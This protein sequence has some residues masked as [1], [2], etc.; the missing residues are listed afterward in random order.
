M[1]CEGKGK[2]GPGAEVVTE[3]ER[4]AAAKAFS[5]RPSDRNW[6]WLYL[7]LSGRRIL[8]GDSHDRG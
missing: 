2:A 1:G 7:L 4:I 6:C 8:Q 3:A 5:S